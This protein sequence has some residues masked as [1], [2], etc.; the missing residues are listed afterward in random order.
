MPASSTANTQRRNRAIWLTFSSW[1]GS[2]VCSVICTFAQ[3]PIALSYLHREA[4]G[5]WMTL[6]SVVSL[7]NFVDFG[8]GV[9]IQRSM[10]EAFGRDDWPTLR[11]C[12]WTGAGL[13]ALMGL[14]VAAIAAPLIAFV[15]WADIFKVSDPVLRHDTPAAL[16]I[17]VGA[18]LIGLPF[19]AVARLA[20]GIQRG[21]LHA[22]W[23]V[24]GSVASLLTVIAAS[25]F[26]M[27]FLAFLAAA[28]LIPALQMAGLWIQLSASLKWSLL[29]SGLLS[30]KETRAMLASSATFAFPQVGLALI[31]TL[32]NVAISMAAG[33][34]AVT[35]FNILMRLFGTIQQVQ[36]IYLTPIWPAY[37]EAQIRGDV[38]WIGKTLQQ[39]FV[40]TGLFSAGAALTAWQMPLLLH[41]WLHS[42]DTTPAP[43]LVAVTAC[44]C[45][46]QLLIQPFVYYL[47]G[48]GRLQTLAASA[49][50][51]LI[52]VGGSLFLGVL[53]HSPVAVLTLGSVTLAVAVLP[54]IALAVHRG[55]PRQLVAT[56]A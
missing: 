22:G 5:L 50:P 49:S 48:M 44:W 56:P 12:F 39:T 31:Q 7:F 40:V 46:A 54:W 25:H 24:A 55:S 2:K 30:R 19:N 52:L 47:M 20:A 10:A 13:L 15:P 14:A 33:P 18:F 41:L 21:W 53:A 16:A 32:P 36:I 42:A 38:G 37:T 34:E 29:P 4:Y 51:G 1:T 28:L 43:L 9:G 45:I 6:V 8:L 26:Q 23:I 35:A 27:G 3:V 17:A 11:R